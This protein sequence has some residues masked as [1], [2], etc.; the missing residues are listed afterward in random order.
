[1]KDISGVFKKV[2]K[3][4]YGYGILPDNR[5]FHLR[6]AVKWWLGV[7]LQLVKAEN[8]KKKKKLV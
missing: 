4:F 1:M 7:L 8:L 6:L 2:Q 3:G 5:K